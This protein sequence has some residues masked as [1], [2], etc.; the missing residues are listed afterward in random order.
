MTQSPEDRHYIL[1]ASAARTAT[2]T[3]ADQVNNNINLNVRGVL[4]TLK[5]TA[6]VSSPSIVLTIAAKD[7]ATGD[8]EA[9]LTATAVVGTGIHSYLVY[10]GIG[11]AAAD[12]TQVASYPLPPVW[13]VAV[14][15]GNG[16]SI[17]YSVGVN[18]L[19]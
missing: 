19:P 17:T 8:Y 9:L 7:P 4:V 16:D 15:H 13:R 6:V 2:P 18:L 3:I 1:L 14:V 5:V 10:P 11:V 12:M